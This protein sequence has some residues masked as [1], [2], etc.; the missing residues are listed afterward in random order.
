MERLQLPGA[1]ANDP[2]ALAAVQTVN[3]AI[4]AV[5]M[6]A[7]QIEAD[8]AALVNEALADDPADAS[9]L[10]KRVEALRVRRLS[11]IMRELHIPA[12]KESAQVAVREAAGREATVQQD[13]LAVR[14]GELS[15]AADALGLGPN[16][17]QRT[18]LT[19]SDKVRH[20][21]I[22]RLTDA[23]HLANNFKAVTDADR[24]AVESLRLAIT[25]ALTV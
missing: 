24:S 3:A 5:Q 17:V 11:N 19:R 21:A 12:L 14:E 22:G 20:L 4:D 13:A 25:E 1:V 23:R 10:A 8:G 6:E 2:A 18:Q 9:K 15:D 16:D 7:L